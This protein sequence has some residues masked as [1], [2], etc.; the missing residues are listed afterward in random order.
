MCVISARGALIAAACLLVLLA[1]GLEM[2]ADNEG[3][4]GRVTL[5]RGSA[6]AVAGKERR[7]LAL[8]SV[9]RLGDRLVT[10]EAG[11]LKVEL[12]DGTVLNMGER[13]SLVIDQYVFNPTKRES[14]T[15]SLRFIKGASRLVT[16]QMTR[17]NPDRFKVRTSLATIGIRGCETGIRGD[18][19]KTEVF[20]IELGEDESVVILTTVD[21]SQVMKAETGARLVVDRKKLKAIT[22]EKPGT[23]INASTGN[24]PSVGP[25][26]QKE[27][28]RFLRETSCLAPAKYDLIKKDGD[29]VLKIRPADSPQGKDQDNVR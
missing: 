5:V 9:V 28:R 8:K 29:A 25:I 26:D 18:M 27:L 4:V 15:C 13:S 21:G 3:D 10:G 22:V 20:V 17:L 7:A 19:G 1:S 24:A 23:V 12:K 14:N 11:R 2:Y 16:G 6:S